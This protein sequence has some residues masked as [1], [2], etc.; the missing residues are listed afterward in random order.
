MPPL[1][2][3]LPWHL[4]AKLIKSS[5]F[6]TFKLVIFL[7]VCGGG[8]GGECWGQGWDFTRQCC[9][10]NI[11]CIILFLM[12]RMNLYLFELEFM[13]IIMLWIWY[14]KIKDY[15][16]KNTHTFDSPALLHILLLTTEVSHIWI[17]SSSKLRTWTLPCPA[18]F[19]LIKKASST[20]LCIVN[21]YLI[22]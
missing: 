2:W 10:Y 19:L 18:P 8:G 16:H 7:C 21:A 6:L 5:L 13:L 17:L 14:F 20:T 9:S 3:N 15:T 11:L 4:P 22:N 1:I 12:C